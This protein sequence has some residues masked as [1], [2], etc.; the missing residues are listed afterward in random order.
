MNLNTVFR[1]PATI[2]PPRLVLVTPPSGP[3]F[4][5]A[6]TVVQQA[7]RLDSDTADS[8]MVDMCMAAAQNYF[9][10]VTG[11]YLYTQTWKV[12]FDEIPLR[13]GQFGIE[14][15]LAP[16]MSRFTGTPAGR[17]IRFPRSPLVSVDSF[18]YLDENENE[19]TFDPS[20]YTVGS[21]GVDTTCGRLWLN[22]DKGWPDIGSVPGAIRITFTCGYGSTPKSVPPMIR[23]AL[24]QLGAYW[25][26]HRLPVGDG[27]MVSIPLHL[28]NIIQSHKI[29]F[30]A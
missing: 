22:E 3:V 8:E 11:V 4:S 7:L 12:Y 19:Q 5:S 2:D 29:S 26:E 9:E 13:Q 30:C 14:Y 20:N 15:G 28:A 27:S 21:I 18:E 10:R 23:M 25:Y 16:T 6:N 24:I 1:G 17:E